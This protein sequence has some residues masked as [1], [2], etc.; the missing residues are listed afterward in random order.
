[1]TTFKSLLVSAIMLAVM[2][3][4]MLCWSSPASAAA[5]W[6]IEL[7]NVYDS[8]PAFNLSGQFTTATADVD[9]GLGQ[10][11]LSFSGVLNGSSIS[12]IIPIGKDPAY[13]YDN[14]FF[15]PTD[16]PHGWSTSDA[17]DNAGVVFSVGDADINMYAGTFLIALPF[18]EYVNGTITLDRMTSPVPE[19]AIWRLWACF[20]IA[21]ACYY[22]WLSRR[23]K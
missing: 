18:N 5:V 17:F 15:G 6:D 13:D 16:V 10:Q 11:I 21:V 19:A 7:S 2:A 3:L 23:T 8:D 9:R 22:R 4:F 14:R 12:G 1:M 20:G